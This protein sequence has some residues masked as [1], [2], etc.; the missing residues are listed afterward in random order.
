LSGTLAR[1]GVFGARLE[2]VPHLRELLDAAEVVFRPSGHQARDLGAVAGW[3][4]GAEASE[5]AAFA[6][7]HDLPLLRVDDG[8]LRS[9][10]TEADGA[11]PLSLLVDDLG[12]HDDASSP[13]RLEALLEESESW[14]TPELRARAGRLRARIVASKVSRTNY[15]TSGERPLEPSERP[16]V[17]VVHEEP[18][19]QRSGEE[20]SFERM[21]EAALDEHPLAEVIVKIEAGAA[22]PAIPSERVR[23]VSTDVSPQLLFEL[24]E[25]VYVSDSLLGFEALLAERPVRCFGSPFYAGWGLTRDLHSFPRRTRRLPLDALVAGALLVYPRYVDPERGTRCEAERVVEHLALQRALHDAN[26]R[27][28]FA[29]GF[30]RWKQTF[31]PAFLESPR[32]A[33][34]FVK[35]AR[36]ARRNG[37]DRG[38]VALVWSATPPAEVARLVDERRGELWRMEDGFLRSVRLGAEITVPASLVVDTRGIYFDPTGPSDLEHLLEAAEIDAD[39]LARARALRGAIV[40]AGISKYNVGARRPPSVPESA[41]GRVVLVPGQVEDDASIRLGG[42]DVKTNLELLRAVRRARP[43]GYLVY[44]PHPDVWGGHR[45]GAIDRDEARALADLVVTD[46]SLPECLAIADEVHTITSLVGFEGLLRERRVVTYGLPFYAGWGLTE[47][48]HTIAR[49]T[50]RRSV[51]ELVACALIRYPRY[52]SARSGAFATP[53]HILS[54]LERARREAGDLGAVREGSVARSIRKLRNLLRA[55]RDAT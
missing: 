15:F 52:R 5:A 16:R 55:L 48:R 33:P 41:R 30:S 28:V 54:E 19:K 14:V 40:D 44:K 36:E 22:H 53:E 9:V 38:D 8:F 37:F 18:S 45:R 34:T 50:R 39:E 12:V 43:D 42:V 11:P 29:F 46:S 4:R 23:L 3:A 17:V 47:D 10:G 35:S 32:R 26:A 7:A 51:D 20:S 49:R 6:R 21:L 13:S 1:V 24:V 31:V 25:E 27:R 2:S